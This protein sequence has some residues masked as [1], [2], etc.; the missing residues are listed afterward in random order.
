MW[1]GVILGGFGDLNVRRGFGLG[2]AGFGFL[3]SNG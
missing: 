2:V 3:G 1:V